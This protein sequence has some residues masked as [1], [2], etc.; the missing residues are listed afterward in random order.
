MALRIAYTTGHPAANEPLMRQGQVSRILGLFL[1]ACQCHHAGRTQP[2]R[3]PIA[4]ALTCHFQ[5]G[6]VDVTLVGEKGAHVV[7]DVCNGS[8]ESILVL[9]GD[10][11]CTAPQQGRAWIDAQFPAGINAHS[12]MRWS[13]DTTNLS[14]YPFGCTATRFVRYLDE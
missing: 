14:T 5:D 7:V 1:T 10:L 4:E 6:E 12:A 11:F 3:T 8:A 2:K 9:R 13:Q